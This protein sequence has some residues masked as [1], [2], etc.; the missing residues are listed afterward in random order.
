MEPTE[1]VFRIDAFTPDT[2]P[3]ARLA[4]YLTQLAKLIGHAENTH[5]VRVE[6]GSARLVHRVDA[7][8][9]PK[10]ETRLNGVRLGDAAKDALAAHR[11]LDEL[12]LNDNAIGTLTE[13]TTGRIVVPFVGRNRPKLLGFPSFRQD[14]SIDGQIVSIGGRDDTAHAVLQDGDV[15]HSHMIMK[16]ELARRLAKFLYGPVVRLHGSGRYERRPD[17]VWNMID[18]RVESFEPLDEKSLSELMSALRDVPDNGLM[19]PDA[20]QALADLRGIEEAGR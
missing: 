2:L 20:Y 14:A 13:A 9:A 12:L 15:F 16:R 7:V 1:Y 6:A 8:D 4:E 17:G 19:R 18:F 5:F 11:A 3:M 10:V